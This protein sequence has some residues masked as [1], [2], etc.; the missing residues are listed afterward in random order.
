MQTE[1]LGGIDIRISGWTEAL[2][3]QNVALDEIIRS[4][5]EALTTLS[6]LQLVLLNAVSKG[7][8]IPRTKAPAHL[9]GGLRSTLQSFISVLGE[10]P[11]SR[12]QM[13][14]KLVNQERRLASLL[15][16]KVEQLDFLFRQDYHRPPP[17]RYTSDLTYVNH[18]LRRPFLET[19]DL[20]A[21]KSKPVVDPENIE[22]VEELVRV[23]HRESVRALRKSVDEKSRDGV[24]SNRDLSES[25]F[26]KDRDASRVTYVG[27]GGIRGLLA[28][29]M[30]VVA[31]AIGE[32]AAAIE[33]G[34]GEKP[35][36][37][38]ALITPR[39]FTAHI[40]AGHHQATLNFYYEENAY[41]LHWGMGEPGYGDGRIRYCAEL[42]PLMGFAHRHGFNYHEATRTAGS[43]DVGE[44]TKF[45]LYISN[46]LGGYDLGG[47]WRPESL[48]R[49]FQKR[50]YALEPRDRIEALTEEYM[51]Q[52]R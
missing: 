37:A 52:I 49:L 10:Y 25:S 21:G 46:S 34:A 39:L 45:L 41:A 43:E 36:F 30:G 3:R 26:P 12:T 8:R 14:E 16:P 2:Q 50:V 22:T 23:T 13:H 17:L 1:R 5:R 38:H 29:P 20:L 6:D 40:D 35:V 19:A 51:R 15:T 27:E 48:V 47:K 9:Y 33:N 7:E 44:L 11:L 42:M 31:N 28:S 24:G 18:A 32:Y 4:N